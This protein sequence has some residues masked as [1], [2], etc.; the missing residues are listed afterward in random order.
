[1]QTGKSAQYG[2]EIIVG[3]YDGDIDPMS[4]S[5]VGYKIKE[6]NTE[7]DGSGLTYQTGEVG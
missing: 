1:M 2:F 4:F 5:R 7:P 3:D 6:W